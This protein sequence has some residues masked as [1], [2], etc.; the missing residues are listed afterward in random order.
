MKQHLTAANVRAAADR[1]RERLRRQHI[2]QAQKARKE[3]EAKQGV[4]PTVTVVD[5][6]RGKDEWAVKPGGRIVYLFDAVPRAHADLLAHLRQIAPVD[7]VDPDDRV[8]RDSFTQLVG[9][10]EAAIGT[11][12]PGE[13]V[14]VVN[15][16]PYSR[17]LEWGWSLQAPTGVFDV[18]AKW[19]RKRWGRAVEVQFTYVRLEGLPGMEDI[20]PVKKKTYRGDSRRYPAI[21]LR[22]KVI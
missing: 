15:R 6:Q 20:K 22:S 7:T 16:Q 8:F 5:S 3:I 17:K 11:M 2:A 4:S 12:K 1:M 10:V 14:T 9:E 13:E 18:A 19:L 21:V